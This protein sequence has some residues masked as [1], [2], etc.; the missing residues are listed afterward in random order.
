MYRA[1]LKRPFQVVQPTTLI[2]NCGTAA[3]L[4]PCDQEA[5]LNLDNAA[6][7]TREQAAQMKRITHD[8]EGAQPCSC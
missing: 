3:F 8:L 2:H 5:R 7:V 1:L 6:R 4:S